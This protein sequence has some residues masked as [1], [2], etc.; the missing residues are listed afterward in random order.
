MDI[1]IPDFGDKQL[2]E[3]RIVYKD[4]NNTLYIPMNRRYSY[5]AVS[6]CSNRKYQY[7]IEFSTE[8]TSTRFRKL[9]IDNYGRGIVRPNVPC[10]KYLVDAVIKRGGHVTIAKLVENDNQEITLLRVDY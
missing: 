1:D 3:K 4:I 10:K 2:K 5:Y 6:K 8:Y 9:E 7:A